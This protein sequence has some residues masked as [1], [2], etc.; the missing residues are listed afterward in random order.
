MA[1][2]GRSTRWVAVRI[3]A[4]AVAA[5][6][7][8]AVV[9]ARAVQLQV[10]Q[11]EKLGAMA[12]DQYVRE[13]DWKPRRG[14][15]TDRNGAVLAQDVE[16]DSVFVDPEE[17]PERRGPAL[18][19]LAKVLSV[20]GKALERKVARGG[21]FAWVKRRISPDE[22]AAVRALRIPGVGFAKE[23]RR[24]YP[25]R[26]LAAQLVGFVG[27]DGD[28]LEGVERLFDDALSGEA[29]RV[30]SLRDAR[31]VM[32][33]KDAPER[34][35][36]GARVE[37]T[38]DQGLQLAAERA[39]SR[40]VTQARAA[41]GM[42][43]ALDPSTGEVLAL[44]NAPTFNPNT[45]RRGEVLRNRAVLDSFE[46][47]STFKVF[48]LVGALDAGV[49]RAG[50]SF[51]CEK[52]SWRVGQNVL[53]DSHPIGWAG[54]AKIIAESSNICAAKVGQ[55]LGR[56]RLQRTLMAFGFG[57]KVG[58]DLPAEPRG[59]VPFPR[60]EV[61]LAT[62]SFGHGVTAT[63]LQITAGVAAIANGGTLLRPQLVRRVVDPARGPL[64]QAAPV[65][66]R[67][68][69]SPSAAAQMARWMEGVVTEGTGKRARLDGWR[70]AGKTG[71]AQKVDPL[72]GGYSADKRF[73]SFV[74]FA[75]AEEPRIVIGVFI[76]EPRGEVMGGEVAAPVF[77]EVAEHALRSMSVRPSGGDPAP[78]EPEPV[79]AADETPL[80]S[81]EQALRTARPDRGG[82]AVPVLEGLPARAALQVL[83]RVE[84]LGETAGTG[85]VSRQAPAPGTV[86][87]PGTR[88]R[89]TLQP[90]G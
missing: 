29:S 79:A 85:L 23:S 15:I 31:G 1:G 71:T 44:A 59:A 78:R 64:L 54:P 81:V 9:G 73:S 4:V 36:E 32:L 17:L 7:G 39:L 37:L 6:A 69:A 80:P 25:R 56:E 43:V 82:V 40:A 46:P 42:L 84:L 30:P 26:E 33:L 63:P 70:A 22:S 5:V 47:G 68:A 2:G 76:D 51:Y 66:V 41:A 34:A 11:S 24:Y 18:A 19:R 48:T 86:V 35:I 65:A 87:E 20:E 57:E 3:G 38:I 8:F 45:P 14:A 55:R 50:D 90:R 10:V 21:R 61:A 27:D 60:A 13:L 53:H 77:K 88:V 72:S 89:L 75:P 16:A 49:L 74:G 12:R 67:R 83:E 28:G 58:T 52:G 62:M